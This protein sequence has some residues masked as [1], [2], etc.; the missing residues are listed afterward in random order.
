MPEL[1][2]VETIKKD[3]EKSI[4]GRSIKKIE[5]NK[6]RIIKEPS[7]E[8][9]KRELKGKTFRRIV[10]RGKYLIFYLSPRKFLIIHLRLTGQLIYGEKDSK[11]RLNLLLSNNK[12]LNLNSRRMLT[13]ARLV[14]DWKKISGITK[15]GYE[16]LSQAFSLDVFRQGINKK[17]KNIKAV[18]MDQTFIAGVGNIYSQEALFWAKIDPRRLACSLNKQEIKRLHTVLK[19]IL[20]DAV[21][22]RGS[23]IS[24]YTDARGKKG[25][26]HFRFKVY[27]R[28]GQAC[29]CCGRPLK[30]VAIEGRTTCFCPKCQK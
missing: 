26:F 12:Y 19:K 9:F 27:G 21:K 30:K 23:S 4:L 20:R 28:K 25:S 7:L 8:R 13:E 17:K 3:L 11:N 14:D 2:E 10:R 1:P 18:L 24:T 29:L 6:P 22:C 5:V 16:P 15:L